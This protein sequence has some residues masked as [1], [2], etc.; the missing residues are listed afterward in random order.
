MKPKFFIGILLI[1]AV[2]CSNLTPQISGAANENNPIPDYQ[3]VFLDRQFL[4]EG[5]NFYQ[6]LQ[7]DLD[8][9][10]TPDLILTGQNHETREFFIYWLTVNSDWNP[11]I[12]W[13]SP[14]L[15]EEKSI[16]WV[17]TG[18]FTADQEQL[19]AVSNTQL[20]LY[21]REKDSF[22][23]I[24]Q[25]PCQMAPLNLASGDLDGNG[26]FELA[27]AQI[28]QI[29]QQ[30]YNC[31]I[32]IWSYN[33]TEE[34][35]IQKSESGLIGNI[36]GLS[37]GDLDGDGISEI[38]VDEGVRF[39][40]GNIHV[41]KWKDNLIKEEFCLKKAIKGAV[42]AMSIGA[43]PEGNRLVTGSSS[44]KVN[45][46]AWNNQALILLKPEISFQNELISIA[47]GDLNLDHI[48][49]LVITG[50]PQI[51]TLMGIKPVNALQ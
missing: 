7:G 10:Q 4:G 51:L 6:L 39:Q 29:T 47:A 26:R 40:S 11:I 23:L 36:R 8:H 22:R 49:E 32:Q 31:K 2:F 25:A 15:F 20:L 17:A 18:R 16:W 19:L 43:F 28:G 38:V 50:Y 44:G 37:A 33:D 34:K 45:F 30:I 24:K 21:Q 46:L 3:T 14:N 48:P 1:L 41:L 13:Q 35:F 12:R 27:I 5:I 9:D 42:Y